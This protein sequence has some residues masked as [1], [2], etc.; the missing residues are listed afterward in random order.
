MLDAQQCYLKMMT[1]VNTPAEPV[2]NTPAEPVFAFDAAIV[3][4]PSKSVIG[5][6]RAGDGGDPAYPGVCAEHEAYVAALGEA[7]VAVTTLGALEAYPDAMFV[8][9][10][11]LVFCEGAIL[12]RPGALSRAGEVSEIAGVLRDQFTTVLELPGEGFVEGGDV[13]TTPEKVMIGLSSRTNRAGASALQKLL[14]EF[15][16]ASDIVETPAD[17][18]HF[19]TDCSLLDQETVL[20]TERLARSGVFD[21]FDVVLTP[22][23]E[24]A[25][26]NALRV[27]DVVMVGADFP[28]TIELLDRR[29]FHVAP[30]KTTEIGKI[31]AG[32]SCM[33]LRWRREP[34]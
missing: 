10:P 33:S 28:R 34:G 2:F 15:G 13:L 20:A 31:D 16:R 8:E 6:L 7:G 11:A 30:L 25:A 4:L 23:G 3:R 12:L 5:G 29:G 26:A 18:L 19:K 14:A 24:E 1:H 17:V 21:G 27:H 9:D 22:E 32:L